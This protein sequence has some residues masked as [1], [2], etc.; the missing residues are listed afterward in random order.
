MKWFIGA[1]AAMGVIRFTLNQAGVPDSIVKYFSMTVIMM[2]GTLYFA[3][4]STSHKQ[5]LKAAFLL[6]LPYMAVESLA[7]G[8]TW[9]T[10]HQ[11]IFHAEQYSMGFSIAQHT[12][13]H[14]VGGVTWEP[15]F[16]FVVMEIVWVIYAGG[17]TLI[18][19]PE[20]TPQ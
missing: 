1:I 13:G 15:L 14:I 2:A 3:V 5:R 10:G 11:T 17:R 4:A 8:Y 18:K 6:V 9:A 7:L 20:T 16:I 12:I 19:K